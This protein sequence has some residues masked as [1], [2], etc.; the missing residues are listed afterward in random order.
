MNDVCDKFKE[1]GQVLNTD[2][3]ELSVKINYKNLFRA[4]VLND[5][6]PLDLLMVIGRLTTMRGFKKMYI[7]KYLTFR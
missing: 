6:K 7:Q 3:V 4:K 5:K 1:A 2:P